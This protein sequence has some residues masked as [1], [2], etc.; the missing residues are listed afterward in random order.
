MRR[1]G[2][3]RGGGGAGGRGGGG[4][5]NGFFANGNGFLA[6]RPLANGHGFFANGHVPHEGWGSILC[7][8]GAKNPFWRPAL[9]I[10]VA[11]A[12]LPMATFPIK[13]YINNYIFMKERV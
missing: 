9:M 5:G 12:F 8:L 7:E 6:T 10:L 1:G 3:G 2:G 11:T 13:V 4:N